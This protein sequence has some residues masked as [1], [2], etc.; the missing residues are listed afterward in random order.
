MI[1]G[2]F[3]WAVPILIGIGFGVVAMDDYK[4]AKI[5]FL[6]SA[7]IAEVKVL[8]W[9]VETQSSGGLRILVCFMASGLIG[10]LAMESVRYVD[11]KRDSKRVLTQGTA[12]IKPQSQ[13]PSPEQP[14]PDL[15]GEINNI[16]RLDSEPDPKTLKYVIPPGS[17]RLPSPPVLRR[18]ESPSFR[19]TP[20][21]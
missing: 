8:M 2:L 6:L 7:L 3:S 17:K 14:A 11:R 20:I 16:I 21:Y 12:E 10:V 13:L 1:E 15:V 5:C 9:G 4:L 18:E 19:K